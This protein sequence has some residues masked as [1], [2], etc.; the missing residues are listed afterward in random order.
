LPALNGRAILSEM[1]DESNTDPSEAQVP[2][3]EDA[4]TAVRKTRRCA[5]PGC[6]T[7]LS[8]YN[9]GYLCF[10]HSNQKAAQTLTRF[11]YR[12]ERHYSE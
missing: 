10:V 6:L 4:S 5:M 8:T 9:H 12:P 1:S 3:P 11:P 7:T 2:D